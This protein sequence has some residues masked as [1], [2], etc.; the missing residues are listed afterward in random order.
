MNQKHKTERKISMKNVTNDFKIFME[1]SNGVGPAFMST[2]MKIS[3]VSALDQKNHELA[4]LSVLAVLQMESGLLFH[5]KQA[6][7]LGASLEEVKS[8]ILVG[9]PLVGLKISSPF[10]TAINSYNAED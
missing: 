7:T 3:E 4:Y 10:A 5:V 1:E 6:K 2:V 9:M 8:A